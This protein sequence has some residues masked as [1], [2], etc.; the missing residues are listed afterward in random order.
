MF[1]VAFISIEKLSNKSLER[2]ET[3]DLSGETEGRRELGGW[4]TGKRV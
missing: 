2:N 4:G 3:D 1:I